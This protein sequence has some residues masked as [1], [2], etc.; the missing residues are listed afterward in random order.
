[1]AKFLRICPQKVI[2]FSAL[3]WAAMLCLAV[4]A[5]ATNGYFSHGYGTISKSMAG[6][7]VAWGGDGMAAANNPATMLQVGNRLDAGLAFFNP[8]RGFTAN[9]DAQTPPY[10]SIP[11]G[12]YDSRDALFLIPYVGY[13]HILDAD[14]SIGFSLG[15]NGGMLVNYGD[16]VFRNFNSGAN[17]ASSPTSSRLEQIFLGV[18]MA[19]RVHPDHTLGIMPILS[20]Q[21]FEAKGLEPFQAVSAS[22]DRVTNKGMDYSYG[23]GLKLGWQGRMNDWLTLGAS[24]QTRTFMTRFKQYQGLFAEQGDFDIPPLMTVGA[25]FRVAPQWTVLLDLQR[26]QYSQVAAL[27]NSNDLPMSTGGTILGT[28]GG[29]GFGWR[30]QDI[31]KLG[32]QWQYSDATSFRAG[33]SHADQVVPSQQALFNILAPAVVRTHLT[34]GFSQKFA[35]KGTFN[36]SLMHALNER[37]AGTNPNTGP[38]TG[39]L[40][41]NQNEVEVSWTWGF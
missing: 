28:S 34:A 9:N 21:R 1:M 26:I 29:L 31:V 27:G 20:V 36:L 32:V 13:N 11:A 12:S 40:E 39:Y 4:P 6:T 38:Q 8:E 37:V 41:M 14:T 24:Y 25:A 17:L 19:R 16:N 23:M 10:A 18:S 15:A 33:I 5:Q 30:D 3:G 22:P 2:R 7:G 35:D